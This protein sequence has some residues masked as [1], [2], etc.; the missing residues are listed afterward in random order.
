MQELQTTLKEEQ[1]YS[2]EL[3]KEVERL[4]TAVNNSTESNSEAEADIIESQITALTEA[5]ELCKL[6]LII[7]FQPNH[8]S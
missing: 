4:S 1:F 8:Y 3:K 2:A 5:K 7:S 6:N